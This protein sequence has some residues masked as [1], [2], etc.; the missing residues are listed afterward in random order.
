M[1]HGNR[2]KRRF[3]ST[4]RSVLSLP[5][6]V[7]VLGLAPGFGLFPGTSFAPGPASLHAEPLVR[8]APAFHELFKGRAPRKPVS[9][10][11]ETEGV[12]KPA[13][14][15]RE[16]DAKMR[17]STTRSNAVRRSLASPAARGHRP[18]S[19][20]PDP[21]SDKPRLSSDRFHRR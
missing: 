1:F 10:R 11:N 15:P 13:I 12:W 5:A 3:F 9:T 8:D 17:E 7:L 18:P 6:L 20:H 14:R 16:Y 4:R 21:R 19:Y 2:T